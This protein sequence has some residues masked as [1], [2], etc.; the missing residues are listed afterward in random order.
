MWEIFSAIT[1]QGNI[2]QKN[3]ILKIDWISNAK[4]CNSCGNG[5]LSKALAISYF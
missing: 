5:L 2:N 4:L 1:K 3:Y